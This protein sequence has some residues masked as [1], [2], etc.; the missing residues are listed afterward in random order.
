M[1]ASVTYV[2]GRRIDSVCALRQSRSGAT[3]LTASASSRRPRNGCS[4]ARAPSRKCSR[5]GGTAT[6]AASAS[7]TRPGSLT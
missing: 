5:S 4:G 7:Q 3:C 2:W 6:A 1:T